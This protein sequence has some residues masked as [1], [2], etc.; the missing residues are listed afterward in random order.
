MIEPSVKGSG[1]A[2]VKTPSEELVEII[3]P[4]LMEQGLLLPDDA[5]KSKARF[6]GGLMKAEDWLLAAEKAAT[7]GEK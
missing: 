3:V 6:S 5:D 2:H 1:E 7:K 4:L